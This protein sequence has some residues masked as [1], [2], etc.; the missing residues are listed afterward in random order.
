MWELWEQTTWHHIGQRYV[1]VIMVMS[2][3]LQKQRSGDC[4]RP[5]CP[6]VWPLEWSRTAQPLSLRCSTATTRCWGT[7]YW[8]KYLSRN[9]QSTKRRLDR[10]SWFTSS[11]VQVWPR[12]GR[13]K[14]LGVSPLVSRDVGS[15]PHVWV[16]C[17]PLNLLGKWLGYTFRYHHFS[18][19]STVCY[20]LKHNTFL[21]K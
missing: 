17:R 9:T 21:T 19:F 7:Y 10:L 13:S 6:S 3:T 15:Q 2:M 11:G 1:V 20:L 18:S 12:V 14:K 4:Y 8:G 16:F 5:K